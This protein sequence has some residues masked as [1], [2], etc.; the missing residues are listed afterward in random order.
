MNPGLTLTFRSLTDVRRFA[1][2][3]GVRSNLP[4]TDGPSGLFYNDFG[5]MRY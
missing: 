3:I 5:E 2:P 1:A 4:L